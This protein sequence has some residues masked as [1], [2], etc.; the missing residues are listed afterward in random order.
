MGDVVGGD[1]THPAL[2]CTSVRLRGWKWVSEDVEELR[3]LT[4]RASAPTG[5]PVLTQ[6]RHRM[7]PVPGTLHNL[8]DIYEIRFAE[9]LHGV[10]P[11]QVGAAWDG[12]WC[13]G[14]GEIESTVCLE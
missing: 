13:L 14:C 9:P 7:E 1:R 10:A 3:K 8:G 6:I 2:T 5:L 11:G 4:E 12:E